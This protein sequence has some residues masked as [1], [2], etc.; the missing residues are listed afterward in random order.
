MPRITS[1]GDRAGLPNIRKKGV[2]CTVVPDDELW[3][4]YNNGRS[5]AQL[6]RSID[7]CLLSMACIVECTHTF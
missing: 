3:A 5:D 4:N 1:T 6:S 2:S 7:L